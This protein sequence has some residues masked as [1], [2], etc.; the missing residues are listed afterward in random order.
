MY[1]FVQRKA[2]QSRSGF[3]FH[4]FGDAGNLG[5]QSFN[6]RVGSYAAISA[7]GRVSLALL[8]NRQSN[9]RY[10]EAGGK[11]MNQE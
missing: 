3:I 9:F 1:D 5:Y 2:K 4:M 6:F 11:I 8:V 7:L 10:F